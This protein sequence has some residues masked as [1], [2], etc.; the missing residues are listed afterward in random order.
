[1]IIFNLTEKMSIG[2]VSGYLAP[3]LRVQILPISWCSGLSPPQTGAGVA[4]RSA[5][6]SHLVPGSPGHLLLSPVS[7]V[8]GLGDDIMVTVCTIISAEAES[9]ATRQSSTH[10][11]PAQ[12]RPCHV[13]S[14]RPLIGQSG[15]RDPDTGFSL[16]V[17]RPS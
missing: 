13:I 4:A 8:W 3:I 15:S 10:A 5:A 16:A 2:R 17:T 7:G 9:N 12:T 6:L 11:A 1:M 14:V